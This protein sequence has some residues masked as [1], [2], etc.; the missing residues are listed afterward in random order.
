MIAAHNYI[1]D[2]DHGIARGELICKQSNSVCP[3][4]IGN[5]VWLG[6]C[7]TILKGSKI[8]N[9]AVIGA[10]ALVKGEIPENAIAVG[11]PAKV[12]RYR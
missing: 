10:K 5:D 7:A 12:L 11:I 8:G 6:A 4:V 9:G 2:M 3:V 1:I